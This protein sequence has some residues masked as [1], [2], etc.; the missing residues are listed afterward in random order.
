MARQ[1]LGRQ[2]KPMWPEEEFLLPLWEQVKD[3]K[4]SNL[5]GGVRS[6]PGL[7]GIISASL[8]HM[9]VYLLGRS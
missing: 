4:S 9:S 8:G 2:R 5:E 6:S 7:G 3:L 1:N